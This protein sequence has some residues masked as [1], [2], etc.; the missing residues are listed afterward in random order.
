MVASFDTIKSN[1]IFPYYCV[2]RAGLYAGRELEFC[3]HGPLLMIV[4]TSCPNCTKPF[5]V[6]SPGLI[7]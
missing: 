1:I 6:R 2:Q 5:V 4:T 3:P 7:A